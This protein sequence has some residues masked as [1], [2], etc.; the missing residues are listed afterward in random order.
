M[1][2]KDFQELLE[3]VRDGKAILRGEKKPAR[4]T[5]IKDPDA[6][7]IRIVFDLSQPEFAALLN[8]SVKT[9]RNWEQ[10]RRKP[11]GPA[12]R[13]LQIVERHPHVFFPDPQPA[14]KGKSY[15][16]IQKHGRAKPRTRGQLT[17]RR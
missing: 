7:R 11:R 8:I 6:K 10:G 5:V 4:R 13:L 17:S 9:L 14:R 12:R 15:V 1:K 16:V 3:S 2:D